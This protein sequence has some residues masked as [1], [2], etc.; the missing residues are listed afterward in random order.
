MPGHIRPRP[1]KNGTTYQALWRPPGDGRDSERRSKTFRTKRDAA[2]WLANIESAAHAGAYVDPRKGE[3]LF[4]VVAAEWLASKE[5]DVEP[6]THT[7]YASTIRSLADGRRRPNRTP[8]AVQR[9]DRPH[10]GRPGRGLAEADRPPAQPPHHDQDL[11]RVLADH[12]VRHAARLHRA[13]PMPERQAAA[14]AARRLRPR[15]RRLHRRA[16]TGDLNPQPRRDHQPRRRHANPDLRDGRHVRRLDGPARER[17]MGAKAQGRRPP[18]RRRPR[19]ARMEGSPNPQGKRYF[20]GPLKTKAGQ[21][22]IA[23]PEFLASSW[24]PTS[25]RTCPPTPRPGCSRARWQA[26]PSVGSFYK[27][28]FKP[29]V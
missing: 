5:D 24:R 12:G 19:P 21:R 27:R 11:W 6:R 29:A 26:G 28:T 14:S 10:H 1:N 8:P 16:A 23:M 9:T 7:D 20:L 25:T 2:Q 4:G 13:E 18:A 22:Y 15:H 3:K 17:A